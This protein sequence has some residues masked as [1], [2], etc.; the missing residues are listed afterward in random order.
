MD[1][2]IDD[3][4]NAALRLVMGERGMNE[5]RTLFVVLRMIAL[6]MDRTGCRV[7]LGVTLCQQ[8]REMAGEEEMDRVD[9]LRRKAFAMKRKAESA[10]EEAAYGTHGTR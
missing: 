7:P 8:V 9:A 2:E 4:A 3:A 6:L 1:P 5:W 10:R